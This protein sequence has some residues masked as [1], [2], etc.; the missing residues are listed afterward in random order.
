[1]VFFSRVLGLSLSLYFILF[2]FISSVPYFW[3]SFSS[4]T[5]E[6]RFFAFKSKKE[7]VLLIDRGH[8]FVFFNVKTRTTT[9]LFFSNL[10]PDDGTLGRNPSQYRQL[11]SWCLKT[12][13]R[14]VQSNRL[15]QS[16]K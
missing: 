16:I 11:D 2:Y 9:T 7:K 10:N 6:I 15:V 4:V 5:T 14:I 1:M 8:K 13:K 12:E 3:V